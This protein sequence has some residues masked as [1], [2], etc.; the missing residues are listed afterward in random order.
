MIADL[1]GESGA[2]LILMRRFPVP[3]RLY[4]LVEFDSESA[5]ALASD[6]TSGKVR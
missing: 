2:S 5:A 1:P 6:A 4:P 3:R